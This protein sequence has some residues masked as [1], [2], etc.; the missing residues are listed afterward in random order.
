V[1]IKY[2][3]TDFDKAMYKELQKHG[4]VKVIG[5]AKKY[6]VRPIDVLFSYV[7]F[8]RVGLCEVMSKNKVIRDAL[9]SSEDVGDLMQL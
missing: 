4:K 3:F 2:N 5:L 6:G 7:K 1:N 8:E 9:E